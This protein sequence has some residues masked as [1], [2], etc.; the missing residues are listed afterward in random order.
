[1]LHPLLNVTTLI[2]HYII[3]WSYVINRA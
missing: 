2:K 1:M 3:M